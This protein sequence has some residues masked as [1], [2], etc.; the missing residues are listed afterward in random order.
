MQEHGQSEGADNQ[1]LVRRFS[2]RAKVIFGS[3]DHGVE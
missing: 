1:A 3:R 2:I